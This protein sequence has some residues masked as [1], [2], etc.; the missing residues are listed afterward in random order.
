LHERDQYM[1]R[2][3]SETDIERFAKEKGWLTEQDVI[4]KQTRFP[5]TDEAGCPINK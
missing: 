2:N 3:M 5:E 4:L 1:I